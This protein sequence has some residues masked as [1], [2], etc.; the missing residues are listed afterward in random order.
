MVSTIK[1]TLGTMY[2]CINSRLQT[3][4]VHE[5]KLYKKLHVI[6]LSVTVFYI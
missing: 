4:N 3:Y 5:Q 1:S 6:Y 2:G